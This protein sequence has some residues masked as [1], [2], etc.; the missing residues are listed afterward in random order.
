MV[1]TIQTSTF[2]QV[3]SKRY[4]VNHFTCSSFAFLVVTGP[5]WR[6]LRF[7]WPISLTTPGQDNSD[8][9]YITQTYTVLYLQKEV[10]LSLSYKVLENLIRHLGVHIPPLSYSFL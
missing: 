6:Y 4:T 9:F 1:E 10:K 2:Y 3:S 5:C 7:E 8:I